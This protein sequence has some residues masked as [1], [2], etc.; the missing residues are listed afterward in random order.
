MTIIIGIKVAASGH[1]WWN[2]RW[3][4]TGAKVYSLAYE[5]RT[6]REFHKTSHAVRT[7]NHCPNTIST[8]G[9]IIRALRLRY[10]A[11]TW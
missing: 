11:L 7:E 4:P 9:S 2:L 5:L 6:N 10:I 1:E 8:A 3:G